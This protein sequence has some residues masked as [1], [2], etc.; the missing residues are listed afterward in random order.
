MQRTS[1]TISSAISREEFHRANG[2]GNAGG[3]GP[4]S[5][6]L[7]AGVILPGGRIVLLDCT[8]AKAV[9]EPVSGP[10][11]LKLARLRGSALPA[12]SLCNAPESSHSKIASQALRRQSAST[13]LLIVAGSNSSA[14]QPNMSPWSTTVWC[15]WSTSR[16]SRAKLSGSTS[17]AK[18]CTFKRPHPSGGVQGNRVVQTPRMPATGTG[19]MRAACMAA[20]PPCET[21][22]TISFLCP[23]SPSSAA[24]RFRVRD[25]RTRM[26]SKLNG[27]TSSSP[28]ALP[29]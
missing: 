9:L 28:P 21:P 24:S 14:E 13:S 18:R 1:S 12:L 5:S 29:E 27:S 23:S 2:G 3:L 4:A 15:S 16:V 17:R 10:E 22:P 7:F 11:K 25:N 8:S 20:A 19:C 26:S 6:C